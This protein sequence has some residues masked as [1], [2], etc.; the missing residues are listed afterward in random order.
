MKETRFKVFEKARVQRSKT[1]LLAKK[2]W[3]GERHD[4]GMMVDCC[5]RQKQGEI[6]ICLKSLDQN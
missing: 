2:N 3:S 4:V 1:R 5:V 6:V